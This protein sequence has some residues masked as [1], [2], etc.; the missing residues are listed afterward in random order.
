MTRPAAWLDTV[1]GESI[2]FNGV[3]VGS[4]TSGG[5]GYSVGAPLWFAFVKPD[6]GKPGNK[7]EVMV[8]GHMIPGEVL[9]EPAFDPQSTRPRA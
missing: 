2:W 9:G 5:Y 8:Q 7:V 4:M 3:P 1:G 6:A